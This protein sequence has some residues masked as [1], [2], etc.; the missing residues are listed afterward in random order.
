MPMPGGGWVLLNFA[1]Q[2]AH[3][4]LDFVVIVDDNSSVKQMSIWLFVDIRRIANDYTK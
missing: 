4:N 1:D 3:Q 2:L